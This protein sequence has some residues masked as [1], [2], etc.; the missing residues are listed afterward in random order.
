MPEPTPQAG[1]VLIEIKACGICGTDV[2]VKH[3]NFPYW[4]PVILGHEFAG[5]IVALG[6]ETQYYAVGDRVVGEPHTRAC[7]QCYLCRSGNIQICP[8]NARPAG[9]LTAP[10]PDTW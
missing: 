1:E 4:P 10:S 3:D 8:T 2:H 5:Q 7:G 9:A 6:P